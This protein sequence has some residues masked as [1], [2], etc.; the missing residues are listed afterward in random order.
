VLLHIPGILSASEVSTLRAELSNA[1]FEDGAGTAGF[2]ARDVK[3]NVQAAQDADATR[4]CAALVVQALQRNPLFFSAA[5]P[6]RLH[7]PVFNRYDVGM[8][9]G[10]HV[11]NA[12][13]GAAEGI[14][15]DISATLFL[16]PPQEYEGGELVV[17]DGGVRQAIKLAPGELFLYPATSL[18]R[19][20]PVRRGARL[21]AVLWIQSRV[22]DALRRRLLFDLDLAL[23]ALR[24]RVPDAP[25]LVSVAA[26]YHNLLRQWAES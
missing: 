12:L 15:A 3:R 16:T 13:M 11:D 10:E 20:E 4:R 9:Y 7:G 5:L 23:G 22:R 24:Q 19:V 18:H 14:R 8:T 6:H 2:L 25:E 17:Q 26:V 21:A 1:C